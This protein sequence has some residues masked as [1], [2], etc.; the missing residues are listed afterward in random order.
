LAENP[1]DWEHQLKRALSDS[2]STDDNRNRARECA[3]F[4]VDFFAQ[5]KPELTHLA[6]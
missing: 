2:L 6:K 4:E 5:L 1:E 3:I